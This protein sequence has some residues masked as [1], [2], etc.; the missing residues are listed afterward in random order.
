MADKVEMAC[1]L[2]SPEVLTEKSGEPGHHTSSLEKIDHDSCI[3]HGRESATDHA[4]RY[5]S[6]ALSMLTDGQGTLLGVIFPCTANI[7][8]VL[9]FLRLPWIVGKAGIL[10]GFLLVLVCCACTFI[11]SLSLSAIATNGKILG[12]GS[13]YLISRSLGPAVGAGVGLCFYMANSIGAAMYLMGTVEA[14]EI[15]QPG[16]QIVGVGDINNIR[17]TSFCL[18]GGALLINNMGVKF[19]SRLGIVFLFTVFA[20]IFCMYIGC[21]TNKPSMQHFADNFNAAYTQEQNAFPRD[22]TEHNFISLMALWFPAVTGIMA[23]SNRSADLQDPAKSIPKGTLTAQLSTSLIYLSFVVLFGCAAPRQMLLD[24]PFFAATYAWPIKEVVIYGVMASTIGA[25]LTS[26]VSGSR[27]LSAIASDGTLPILRIFAASP[28]KEPRLALLASGLLC[29][30]AIA[31]GQLNA[32]APILTMFF[33]MCYT[34]VNISCVLQKAVQD[35]NWRPRFRF[36]HWSVSLLGAVLCVWMMFAISWI[37]ALGAICFCCVIFAYAT[38]SSHEVQWGD[39]IQGVKF[40]LAKNFLLRVDK[41]THTKNWR[42]QILVLTAATQSGDVYNDKETLTLE[43]PRLLDFVSQLKGGRG[44]TI[45]GAV[46]EESSKVGGQKSTFVATGLPQERETGGREALERII[47]E[48]QIK[49]F[50]RLVRTTNFNEGVSCLAQIA[51][52]GAFQPNC[53]LAAWPEDWQDQERGELVRA[54]FL[55]TVQ[56]VVDMQKVMLV[57][58]GLPQVPALQKCLSGTIDIWW[59]VADGGILLLL[60]FLLQKHRVWQSCS[61]RLFALASDEE[62]PELVKSELQRYLSDFRLNV[63]VH[64]KTVS[65]TVVR[66]VS[67]FTGTSRAGDLPEEVPRIS[68]EAL[69]RM[70]SAGPLANWRRPGGDVEL[71]QDHPRAMRS[72]VL[73]ML[74]ANRSAFPELPPGSNPMAMQSVSATVPLGEAPV[75]SISSCSIPVEGKIIFPNM[76]MAGN[77]DATAVPAAGDSVE[78]TPACPAKPEF[79][80]ALSIEDQ[81]LALVKGLSKI[82]LSESE[83]AELVV[84]NLPDMPPGESITGYFTLIEEL[85][86]GLQR[87]LLVRGTALE[88]ITAFT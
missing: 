75:A 47:L 22:K 51:G 72:G 81:E 60:P 40:Q 1:D 88:V 12:G 41:K 24:D 87:C 13:Y 32:V 33:L 66:A 50:S 69:P 82:I 45:V 64:V 43:E 27:L 7:L 78:A 85:T 36:Y 26:L 83:S 28:G 76:T 21:F 34:C 65:T 16:A 14:W 11:T 57:A 53:V 8:G 38:H 4:R 77:V 31:I 70:V 62:D 5:S 73:R 56:M 48:H 3:W 46:C 55:H 39:G 18:L 86:R 19:V 29:S 59:I 84:T 67:T 49:G 68:S 44:I 2:E 25:A 54:R 9:L 63:E 17:V 6:A 79:K 35:P 15:A 61:L 30:C 71:C 42:P 23:G 37:Y 80:R 20:V 52:L 58:K 74:S 10:Q